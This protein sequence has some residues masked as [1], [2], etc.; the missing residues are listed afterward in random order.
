MNRRRTFI[1]FTLTLVLLGS[2][3]LWRQTQFSTAQAATGS[4]HA[5][6]AIKAGAVGLAAPLF[7][8]ITVN[9]TADDNTINGN[10]TLR[11]AILAANT[12]AAVDACT[13]GAAGLDNIV[14]NLGAGT[15]SIAVTA[16]ALPTITEPVTLSGN[17]GGATRVELNGAAA[18]ASANGLRITAG[19]ST[20]EGLV[21]N[22]FGQSGILLQTN[23]GNLVRNC[24]VGTNASGTA[25]LGNTLDGVRLES[26]PNNTIGGTTAG[27]RNL[28]SGNGRVGLWIIGVAAAGNKV[29]G[30]YIGTDVNG[31][32]ALGNRFGVQIRSSNPTLGG[33]MV[34]ERNVISGNT[35]VGVYLV[36]APTPASGI[37]V[38]GN[39]I[40]VDVT[41]TTALGNAA[42][43]YTH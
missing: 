18:G 42:G 2:L 26:A 19:N 21:I 27:E 1:G 28:I 38:S 4:A 29:S 10:C 11:E 37:K 41:G 14:F 36:S 24:F 8:I 35:N 32:A 33:T 17:T 20:I 16:S 22:R 12:N 40:G 13:A 43:R 23:G 30:N 34:G 9:T 5:K 25:A 31:T 39:Y 7:A 3:V 15:P 6:L